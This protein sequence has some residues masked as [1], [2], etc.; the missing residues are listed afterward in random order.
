MRG[1]EN[2][3]CALRRYVF[4]PGDGYRRADIRNSG[5][6]A[7]GPAQIVPDAVHDLAPLGHR[8]VG[9][10]MGQIGH[11]APVPME[12]RPQGARQRA[13]RVAGHPRG[14]EHR[15]PQQEGGRTPLQY[16]PGAEPR[17]VGAPEITKPIGQFVRAVVPVA[18]DLRASTR[19]A[20]GK[21]EA[22]DSAKPCAPKLGAPRSV[23]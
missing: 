18:T 5:K 22:D 13:A 7:D 23:S 1:D 9:I 14:C 15:Q 6:F 11:A 16:L 10:D 2:R 8:H 4:Q 17:P 3:R 21:D 12:Q 20:R 19:V